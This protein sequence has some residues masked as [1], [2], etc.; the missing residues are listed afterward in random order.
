M[1]NPVDMVIHKAVRPQVKVAIRAVFPH[2]V[3][4]VSHR[5]LRKAHPTAEL[6]FNG[7][8]HRTP[9]PDD[10]PGAGALGG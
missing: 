2:T 9:R 3:A 5:P 6:N 10:N 8:R 4:N 1:H 7:M